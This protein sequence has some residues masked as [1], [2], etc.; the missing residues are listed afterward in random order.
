MLGEFKRVLKGEDVGT[1]ISHMM[2]LQDLWA[3]AYGIL[4]RPNLYHT[5]LE[6]ERAKQLTVALDLLEHHM[7]AEYN[8]VSYA[9]EINDLNK[10][11]KKE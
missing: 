2:D 5:P 8:L 3:T 4:T 7:E 6:E 9:K 10:A 1:R 11:E